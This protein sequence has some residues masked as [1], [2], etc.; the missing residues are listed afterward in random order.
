MRILAYTYEADIHCPDCALERFPGEPNDKRDYH[1]VP[2]EAQD[3][4]GNTITPVFSTDEILKEDA[5]C[6][7]CHKEL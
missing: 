6:G 4:E 7:S 3:R 5:H 1:G 2:I